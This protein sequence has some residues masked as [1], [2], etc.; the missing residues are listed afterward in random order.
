M[1]VTPQWPR[2]VAHLTERLSA[3]QHALETAPAD[4]VLALQGEAKALRDLLK[5]PETL[6]SDAI[7]RRLETAKAG[8]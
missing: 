1:S 3:V 7:E 2:I 6:S 8:Y 4:R 5:L